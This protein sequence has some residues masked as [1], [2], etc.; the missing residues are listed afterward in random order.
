MAT[1]MIS[2]KAI[3]Y[4]VKDKRSM[5]KANIKSWSTKRL[6]ITRKSNVIVVSNKDKNR[7]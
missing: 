1:P 6:K 3:S 4:H 5:L 7:R 2:P